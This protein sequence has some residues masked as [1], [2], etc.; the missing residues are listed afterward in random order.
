[1]GTGTQARRR[2]FGIVANPATTLLLLAYLGWD[3]WRLPNQ[4][5]ETSRVAATL[6]PPAVGQGTPSLPPVYFVREVGGLV[7]IPFGEAFSGEQSSANDLAV[8]MAT[9]P[10]EVLLV[11][12]TGSRTRVGWY[13]P[14][15]EYQIIAVDIEPMTART[16]TQAERA[17]ARAAYVA[18]FAKHPN[19]AYVE[20]A[21][22]LAPGDGI[23]ERTLVGGQA[24]SAGALAALL[25]MLASLRWIPIAVTRAKDR[26]A[27]SRLAAGKCP[28]CGYPLNGLRGGCCPE[29][30]CPIPE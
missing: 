28:A 24:R 7:P 12:D 3:V 19:A 1:M 11:K 2:R 27:A 21:A 6:F 20:R 22:W 15:T 16:I 5:G 10:G 23:D 14:T 8:A 18:F 17:D 26:F 30:G 4:P 29:C 9:R 13:A 25:L